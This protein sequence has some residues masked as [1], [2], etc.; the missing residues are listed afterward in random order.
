MGARIGQLHRDGPRRKILDSEISQKENWERDRSKAF[1]SGAAFFPTSTERLLIA[2]QI[3]FEFLES[4][5]NVGVFENKGPA[6]NILNISKRIEGNIDTIAGRDALELPNNS[7]LIK[8]DDSTLVSMTPANRQMTTR[9]LQKKISSTMDISSYLTQAVKFADSNADIIVAFDLSGVLQEQEI[10]KRLEESGAV[11]ASVAKIHAKTLTSIKGLTL[12]VTVRDKISGAI[13]VDFTDSPADL[14]AVAKKIL[15]TALKRNGLMIDD[16]ENW[17]M[18]T[19]GNQIR[20]AGPMTPEGLRQVGSL[21]HQPIATDFVGGQGA[22]SG[23]EPQVDMKTRTLQYFG[24][25]Q[26]VLNM[27]RRKDLEQLNTYS[28][29]FSRYAR[30]IDS[31]SVLGVDPAMVAYGTYVANAFRDI[32]GGLNTAQLARNKNVAAQGFSG[33][34]GGRFS[35]GYGYGTLNGQNYTRDSRRAAGALGTEAGANTAKEVMAEIDTETAKLQKAMSE[36]YDI[37]F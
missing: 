3:D 31:I 4:V 8:V 16:F 19:S 29:W 18:T 10:A 36:K 23:E 24:D 5:Y 1:R 34:G 22:G 25:V 21:I 26:H 30:D 28:K 6:L 7:F 17:T 20:F 11:D 15:T 2:S 35:Y 33:P 27:I 9:W 32:S 13:K 37:N 12:G 14:A